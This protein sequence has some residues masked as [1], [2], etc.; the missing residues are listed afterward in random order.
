MTRGVLSIGLVD[1]T[2]ASDLDENVL[3]LEVSS[4]L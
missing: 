1:V 3:E 2:E 4:A